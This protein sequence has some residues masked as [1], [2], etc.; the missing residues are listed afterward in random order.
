MGGFIKW[1]SPRRE[2]VTNGDFEAGAFEPPVT[3]LWRGSMDLS[4]WTVV[5]SGSPAQ[6]VAWSAAGNYADATVKDGGKFLNLASYNVV[7]A[8]DRRYGGITQRI[9]TVA[10][11]KHRLEA[12][13]GATY[14]EPAYSGP[15]AVRVYLSAPVSDLAKIPSALGTASL[16]ADGTVFFI[17]ASS[18]GSADGQTWTRYSFDFTPDSSSTQLTIYG[19]ETDAQTSGTRFVG[20]DDV[21]VRLSGGLLDLVFAPIRHWLDRLMS[22]VRKP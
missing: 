7:T 8:I 16:P 22:P 11:A 20:L 12:T 13:V 1:L 4:G 3:D 17:E 2:R 19:W 18:A 10:G 9:D 21:S 14:I 15:A 6:A 5:D